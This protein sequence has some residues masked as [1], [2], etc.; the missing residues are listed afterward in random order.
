MKITVYNDNI[1]NFGSDCLR[2]LLTSDEYAPVKAFGTWSGPGNETV[3][4]SGQCVTLT[5]HN[6]TSFN[7]EFEGEKFEVIMTRAA[8]LVFNDKN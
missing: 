2:A 8:S 5:F 3:L 1:V 6:R 7:I 4:F